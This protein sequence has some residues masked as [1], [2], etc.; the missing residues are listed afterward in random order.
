[1]QTAGLCGGMVLG[2]RNKLV[3]KDEQERHEVKNDQYAM[4]TRAFLIEAVPEWLDAKVRGE[5][6]ARI[7]QWLGTAA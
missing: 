4:I 2:K 3:G 6:E 7:D 1:M 5:I